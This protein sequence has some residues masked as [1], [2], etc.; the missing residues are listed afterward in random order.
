MKKRIGILTGGGDTS[1]LNTVIFTLRDLLREFSHHCIGFING[2]EGVLE[3]RYINLQAMP[4]FGH[5]GGTYLKSSRVNLA[6]VENGFQRADQ[7]LAELVDFLV[8]IGG[9]DTLSNIYGIENCRCFAVS[10]TIDNDVGLCSRDGDRIIFRNYFTLG[11]PT[12]AE[13]IA[14][15]ISLDEGLRTTAYSHERIIIVESMGMHAGWLALASS[16]GDPD[17]IIIPEF[18]LDYDD[19]IEQVKRQ[20]ARDKNTIIVIAEGA[21]NRDGSFLKQDHSEMDDFG[22]ARFGGSCFVLRDR[23]KKDLAG[24]MNVRNINAVNPSYLYRSGRPN[25]LEKEIGRQIARLIFDLVQED[26]ISDHQFVSVEYEGG[27]FFAHNQNLDLFAQTEQ[28]RFPKRYVD[29]SFYEASNYCASEEWRR[30]LQPLMPNFENMKVYYQ[31][32]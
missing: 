28:G 14:S 30:Y 5:V 20:Y 29:S 17:F 8:V 3:K 12:A 10:K 18:P 26:E 25:R 6:A 23:L 11:Y 31:S 7:H 21:K 4:N 22:H 1:P 2:W 15:Y 9:D 32:I 27:R 19:F 24:F 13:K 16:Q